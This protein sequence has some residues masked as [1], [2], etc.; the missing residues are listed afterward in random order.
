MRCLTLANALAEQA[1]KCSF[2]MR[3]HPGNLIE[4]VRS[5]GHR[6]AILPARAALAMRPVTGSRQQYE[7]W[8]GAQP[9]EDALE[10]I[11]ALS[12]AD[13]PD[14]LVLDHYG[15]DYRWEAELRSH[16]D[17]LMV[18]D[19][20]ADRRHDC[21][22]LLDQ[23][24]GRFATQYQ[25]LTPPTCQ[26]LVGPQYAILRAEFLALREMSLARRHPPH[27]ENVFVFMGG[28]DQHNATRV[29]L[30]QLQKS[31]ISNLKKINVVLGRSS[32]WIDDVDRF[33]STMACPAQLHVNTP[34]MAQL[35][36]EADLCIGAAGSA[37]WERCVLGVPTAFAVLADNQ[38]EAAQALTQTGAAV[39]FNLTAN[40]L[41]CLAQ[42][43]RSVSNNPE[44]LAKV[45]IAASDICDGRGVSRVLNSLGGVH[46]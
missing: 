16:A 25:A 21:D 12:G 31:R 14:W 46:E 39:R 45:S 1:A 9:A 3:E 36:A 37:S 13:R 42:W 26:L 19:D 20:L 38:S 23:N 17:R 22:L 41:D 8:L 10:T 11:Q 7:S 27:C 33:I 18:I 44:L 34:H 43:L 24:L 30:D 15:I 35:M 2:V 29:V 5:Q 4:Q 28:V 6:V 32:P 40:G